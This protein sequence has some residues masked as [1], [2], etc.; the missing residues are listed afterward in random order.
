[1]FPIVVNYP[2][3]FLKTS[4]K[5]EIGSNLASFLSIFIILSEYTDKILDKTEPMC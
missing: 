1:M 3:H 4:A 5:T 2:E